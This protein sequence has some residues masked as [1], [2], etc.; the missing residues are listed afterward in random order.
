[1][2]LQETK[3]IIEKIRPVDETK[4]GKKYVELI[5][6]KNAPKDELGDPIG[7]DD[8]FLAV[9]WEKYFD[10]LNGFK[11]GDPVLAQLYMNGRKRLDQNSKVYY[12]V[13]FSLKN[14]KPF[15]NTTS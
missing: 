15:V 7:E 1:M 11:P 8:L 10:K 12:A 3:F 5:L 9:V 2:Q 6:K 4:N 14:L 13:S